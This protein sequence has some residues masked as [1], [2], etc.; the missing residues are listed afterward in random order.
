MAPAQKLGRNLLYD[1]GKRKKRRGKGREKEE[2]GKKNFAMRSSFVFLR[3]CRSKKKREISGGTLQLFVVYV[4]R[5][6]F[7]E[8]HFNCLLFMFELIV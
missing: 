5:Y 4:L 7:R 8:A 3:T 1:R 6:R 2:R